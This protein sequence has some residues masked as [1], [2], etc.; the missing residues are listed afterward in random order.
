M[1]ED[2]F[3]SIGPPANSSRPLDVDMGAE[4]AS[5]PWRLLGT[6]EGHGDRIPT[7]ALVA[8]KYGNRDRGFQ[9]LI[10]S[11]RSQNQDQ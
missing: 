4:F 5:F 3:A 1:K 6:I 8:P 9:T 7:T 11:T 10:A 2:R